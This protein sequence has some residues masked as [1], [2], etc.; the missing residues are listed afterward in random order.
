[1]QNYPLA[2]IAPTLGAR[3]ETFIYRHMTDILPDQTVV[4]TK[5][6]DAY[7]T[8]NDI[9]FP[10]LVLDDFK[11]S[12]RWF[13]YS[14]LYLIKLNQLSPINM[15]VRRF[16]IKYRPRV[17]L[18]EY[19]DASL[20]WIDMAQNLGIR[21]YAH[22]HGYDVSM[23]LRKPIMHQRYLKLNKADGII[24]V[25]EYSRKKLI[26]IGLDA[27]NIHVIPCCIDIPDQPTIRTTKDTIRCLAVGRM[28]GKKAPLLTLAAF[29]QAFSQNPRLRLDY[30]GDGPFFDKAKQFL[31]DH[32]L[33]G[34]VILHGSQSNSI[35][36]EFMKKADILIQH[37]ITDA[38]TG[39]EEG[40][41]VAILE[42]MANSLP[43][44][45]TRHAGIPEAVIEG[46]TGYLINEGD[47]KGMAS[48]ILQLSNNISSCR[49]LGLA[50]W[51]RA[52]YFFSWEK[53]KSSLLKLM[54]MKS[55]CC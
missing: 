52:K 10:S 11:Y 55:L 34:N 15:E 41:P 24:T 28:V 35:V 4:F 44:I 43:V 3:S 40:L 1:M 21:F 7:I 12:W 19:L 32:S 26:E 38:E 46:V 17:I 30:I 16:L 51:E 50:G 14:I 27:N 47:I 48:H 53:E 31:I 20:K 8:E 42:A 49:Q 54:G 13:Y 39:D 23:A 33:D 37:S 2:V 5:R 6:R 25:S 29:Q 45:S 9:T 22:A 36:Q 18:S